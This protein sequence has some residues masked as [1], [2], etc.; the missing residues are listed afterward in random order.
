MCAQCNRDATAVAATILLVDDEP[1]FVRILGEFLEDEGYLVRRAHDAA[2]ALEVLAHTTIDL[3]LSDINMPGMKGYE[4]LNEI[5]AKYP[6]VKRI[7]ITAYD[8]RDYLKMARMYG[9][10]NI[11]SKSTPFDFSALR[12]QLYSILSGEIFGLDR[13]LQT[14]IKSAAIRTP[15]EIEPVIDRATEFQ[16]SPENT[17]RF[18]Q[19]LREIVVNAFFYGARNE[20]GDRKE[21]W[22]RNV[23]LSPDDE[24]RVFWGADDEKAGVAVRDH[25]GR[26]RREEVL[27]RLERNTRKDPGFTPPGINDR[28]GKG[29][30]LSHEAVDRFIINIQRDKMTEV[31]MLNYH[32][33]RATDGR[34]LWIYEV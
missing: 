1:D 2:Q 30:Y 18:Q 27:Y 33:K 8:I 15:E 7:L 19:V 4:L 3:V 20:R 9:I 21:T 11:F 24:I 31:V 28:H 16:P 26:L 5:E 22:Q 23:T 14:A 34:P 10:G 29:L 6:I 13:Y 12:F 25:G 32:E 17:R